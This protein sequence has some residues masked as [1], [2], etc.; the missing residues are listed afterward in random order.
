[1][2][3]CGW[4]GNR[5]RAS[6]Q[7]FDFYLWLNDDVELAPDTLA[8]LVADADAT[9]ARGSAVIVAAATSDPVSGAISYGAHR[10]ASAARP[11]RLRLV[12]P[13]GAPVAA[14]TISGNIVLVSA[15]AAARLGNLSQVFQHIYGD[16]DYGFRA[17]QAGIPLVL[18]SRVGGSCAAN[19]VAG[20][21]LDPGLSK[22]AR[23]A[24]RLCEDRGIHARDWRRFV[25]LHGGGRLAVA[26]Y[27]LAPYLRILLDRPQRGG[28]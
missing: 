7:N 5:A 10:R 1:M 24:R 28:V 15:A 26:A 9:A 11:L 14:D 2:A 3:G 13:T 19:G 25:R 17:R 12:T 27:T 18:A 8:M 6:G 21:S 20:S 16:L 22:P 23:L 4:R